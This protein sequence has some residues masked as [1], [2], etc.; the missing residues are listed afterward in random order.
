MSNEYVSTQGYIRWSQGVMDV[1]D[2]VVPDG[3][4]WTMV[5][6]FWRRETSAPTT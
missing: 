2:P 4:G 5:G 1:P 6:R 3:D